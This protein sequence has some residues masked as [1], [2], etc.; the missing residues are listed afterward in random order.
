MLWG[1]TADGITGVREWAF[2]QTPA[3]VHVTRTNPSLAS[4]WKPTS[5]GCNRLW[6]ARLSAGS[7]TL[8]PPP[9]P[10]PDS[11]QIEHH[12]WRQMDQFHAR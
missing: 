8:R 11:G 2:S 5:P 12:R 9:N 3:G 10:E 4:R 6:T 1:G 7:P